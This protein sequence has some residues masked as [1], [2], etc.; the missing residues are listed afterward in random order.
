M[1]EISIEIKFK[2]SDSNISF[3][4]TKNNVFYG[5]NGRGKTRILRTIEFLYNLAKTQ[6]YDSLV[7]QLNELNLA[8]LKING[9]S[10]DELFKKYE[11]SADKNRKGF[12]NFILNNRSLILDLSDKLNLLINYSMN[13]G[14][15]GS[16]RFFMSFI[17]T[18]DNFKAEKY[19]YVSEYEFKQGIHRIGRIL[20]DI[21]FLRGRVNMEL[22]DD[23]FI[24]HEILEL[25]RYLDKKMEDARFETQIKNSKIRK[26]L[27]EE[28]EKILESLGKNGAR[29]LTVD[30]NLEADKLFKEISKNFEEINEKY[31]YNIW[32]KDKVE[33]QNIFKEIEL[34]EKKFNTFNKVM[35]RYNDQVKISYSHDGV[36]SFWKNEQVIDFVKLSS[37]EK[38]II[39]IFLNLIFSSEHIILIDEPEISLSLDYQNRIIGDI[40]NITKENKIRIMIATHAP[41]IYEDFIL[42]ED[43]D[44]VKV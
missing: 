8:A 14:F 35:K 13:D 36:I 11:I 26:Q 40:M 15:I 44:S 30:S 39:I 42:Y 23:R 2:D 43:N 34:Y 10:H 24:R 4:L 33:A 6:D 38:R 5:N 3:E 12:E 41:F 29:Y 22:F 21:S 27:Q 9:K 19:K 17:K 18:L 31:I 7:S 32:K 25:V 37:G 16:K 1:N 20:D 28:K